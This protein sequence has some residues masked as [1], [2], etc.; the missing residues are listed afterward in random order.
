MKDDYYCSILAYC[1]TCRTLAVALTSKVYL[2]TEKSGVHY[3]PFPTARAGNFVTCLSFSSDNGGKAILAIS[4]HSGQVSL[5]SLF[6]SEVRFRAAHHNPVSCIA[7]KPV[8]TYRQSA[9]LVGVV[10]CEDLLVADDAGIVL[11]Y[12]VEW[13]EHHSSEI[14]IMV[15]LA[16][17]QA[18]T[19]NICGLAW[20]PT[21][22]HIA[23]GGNDNCALL[24]D[25]SQILQSATRIARGRSLFR[26]TSSPRSISR[27]TFDQSPMSPESPGFDAT[28]Y[29]SSSETPS[30]GARLASAES[31]SPVFRFPY[32]HRMTGITTQ[33]RASSSPARP[34]TAAI[35]RS[36]LQTPPG[37]PPHYVPFD[38]I[39]NPSL[40]LLNNLHSHSF[41]HSAAVKALTFAPWQATLLATG[42]GSN[43]RQIHFHHTGSGATLAVINVLA[44]VTSLNWSKTRREIVAT[45]GYA[46]PDHDIR[47][48]VFSW[49]D[50]KCVVSIP[51]ERKSS[52][53]GGPGEVGRALWAVAYPGGPN[54]GVEVS[55]SARRRRRTER[56][57]ARTRDAEDEAEEDDVDPV[58]EQPRDIEDTGNEEPATRFRV[59]DA[60]VAIEEYGR[61][62]PR[63]RRDASRPTQ[64]ATHATITTPPSS[65]YT[66]HQQLIHTNP[67]GLLTP[68]HSA[69][70]SPSRSRS[71]PSRRTRFPETR[72][73]TTAAEGEP[74]TSRT[75]EEGGLII[76]CCDETVKFFEIWAGDSKGRKGKGGRGLG[77]GIG[78]VLGGSSILEG[79]EGVEGE[80]G[81]GDVLR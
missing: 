38:S 78:G 33:A 50:C 74:W 60:E 55:V 28:Y 76:A 69:D 41:P 71:R 32:Q 2:W 42:G 12:S 27:T 31:L 19:Q 57:R 51:W 34:R 62:S 70:P 73:R 20:S 40:P 30:L 67:I 72:R 81:V 79:L 4:R 29:G 21:G 64:A 48:A 65:P 1:K 63:R 23:T 77:V 26:A 7:F 68:P 44:Q 11:F 58:E 22:D 39:L 14:G 59:W 66:P 8:V 17:I 36:N 10:P 52:G 24:F 25:V 5:W 61:F 15:L 45:F 49:P 37:S 75:Q 16:R 47:I 13:P 80:W 43:D 18:H 56:G 6:E 3:P 46:Q 9:T 54:D 35:T 53:P